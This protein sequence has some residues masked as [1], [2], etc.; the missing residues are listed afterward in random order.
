MFYKNL[1]ATEYRR[2]LTGQARGSLDISGAAGMD[3]RTAYAGENSADTLSSTYTLMAR[4][5]GYNR[6][7]ADRAK[8]KFN[9]IGMSLFHMNDPAD[10]MRK[11]GDRYVSQIT[12]GAYY[13]A[14]LKINYENRSQKENFEAR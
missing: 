11:C 9:D 4:E 12:Y 6:Y 5:D 2:A 8:I 7:V 3:V 10:Q 1:N 14:T 13:T